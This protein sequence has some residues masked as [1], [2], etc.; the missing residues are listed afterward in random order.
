MEQYKFRIGLTIHTNG[1]CLEAI[2]VYV[3]VRDSAV[4]TFNT[5]MVSFG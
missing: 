5:S 1:Y 3:T 4:I 2:D